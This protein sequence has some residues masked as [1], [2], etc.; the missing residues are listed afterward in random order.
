M[1][2]KR[3]RERRRLNLRSLGVLIVVLASASVGTYFVHG[4]QVKRNAGTLLARAR[5]LLAQG[6]GA[7]A[8][9]YYYRYLKF[10]PEDPEA[11]EEVATQMEKTAESERA[12]KTV[13]TIFEKVLSLPDGEGGR[14]PG[15][16]VLRRRQ[17]HRALAL[18]RYVD[19]E[20][21]ILILAGYPVDAV[22]ESEKGLLEHP[23]RDG[24]LLDL[25]GQSLEGQG[26]DKGRKAE[27]A[28]RHALKAGWKRPETYIRLAVLLRRQF[29]QEKVKDA[30]ATVSKMVEEARPKSFKVYLARAGYYAEYGA[31][32][33]A[34]AD[35]AEAYK[36]APKEAGVL[37]AVAQFHGKGGL[38]DDRRPSLEKGAKLYPYD[39]R[40]HLALARLAMGDDRTEARRR[41]LKGLDT[42]PEPP[43]DP[44][45]LTV[46]WSL[47][48]SLLDLGGKD[49][50]LDPAR[51]AIQRL[52]KRLGDAPRVAFLK[53]RVLLAKGAWGDAAKAF[54]ELLPQVAD[55]RGLAK[56]ARFYLGQCY[57]QLGDAE[58]ALAA[59]RQ[60]SDLDSTWPPARL[61]AASA[62]I[63]LGRI[64]DALREYN[65]LGPS[66]GQLARARLRVLQALGRPAG[67]RNWGPVKAAL[68]KAEPDRA[69]SLPVALL[70]AEVY[71]AEDSK[72]GPAK[73]E[74]WMASLRGRYK[75]KAEYWVARA[76]LAER[77]G[78]SETVLALLDEAERAAGPGVELRLARARYWARRPGP[79]ATAALKALE[80]GANKY[81]EGERARLWHGLAGAYYQTG[82]LKSAER[83]WGQVAALKSQDHDLAVRLLLFDLALRRGDEPK[84]RRRIAEIHDKEG[85]DGVLWRYAEAA[86][87]VWLAEGGEKAD[88]AVAARHLQ[89][90]SKRRPSWSRVVLLRAALLEQEGKTS[91][92]ISAYQD[93]VA[94]GERRPEVIRRLV[95]LLMERGRYAEAAAALARL[96]EETPP[97]GDL[98]QLAAEVSLSNHNAEQAARLADS[99]AALAG[100]DYRDHVALAQVFGVLAGGKDKEGQARAKLDEKAR[101]HF[102]LAIALGS[103]APQPWVAFVEYLVRTGRK[104]DAERVLDE[105]RTKLS[106]ADLP[107]ALAPGYELLGRADKAREQ[108]RAALRSYPSSGPVFRLVADYYLRN[109]QPQEAEPLLRRLRGGAVKVSAG[110]K[111]W[112]NRNLAL[113]L[114]MRGKLAE[115]LKLLDENR[116]PR[117]EAVEDLRTRAVVLS[118]HAYRWP[119]AIPVLEDLRRRGPLAPDQEFLLARLYELSGNWRKANGQFLTLL[120]AHQGNRQYLLHY[121]RSLLG[122]GLTR[123]AE[124]WLARLEKVEGTNPSPAAVDLKAMLLKKQGKVEE[125]VALAYKYKNTNPALAAS[126][127]GRLGSK[128]DDGK[129]EVAY[130]TLVAQAGVAANVFAYAGFL[131]RRHRLRE[132]LD[133]CEQGWAKAGPELAAGATV[134]VLRAAGPGAPGPQVRR[135][136][137]WLLAALKKTSAPG[138][139]LALADLRDYEGRYGE[140]EALYR[141]VLRQD[142]GNA[143]AL[144][145]LAWLLSLNDNNHDEA[146]RCV[147]RALERVGPAAGLL[148]TRGVILLRRGDAR[149]AVRDLE[150]VA[151]REPSASRYFHLAQAR[152]GKGSRVGTREAWRCAQGWGLER[153][154]LHPLEQSSYRDLERA[155]ARR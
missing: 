55:T 51:K 13:F 26:P 17:V 148:D 78:K 75:T 68:E 7:Q 37:L 120:A 94:R 91:R 62:A 101:K 116:R 129:A 22:E 16:T 109:G 8:Q 15:H 32:D 138:V 150:E 149:A 57:Q 27:E 135:V 143:H 112:A 28:Y 142:P 121:T 115:A 90:V 39:A 154:T 134:G 119:E 117:G 38:P 60:A 113:A 52:E 12:R 84:M 133:L 114:G 4:Y 126:I 152:Q 145:N 36:L 131:S 86:R 125:A 18:Q 123:E 63:S 44:A 153:G 76:G 139:R 30:D 124:F 50:E 77:M 24:E 42:V 35:V 20:A 97:T 89:E 59:Y 79:A 144:N 70:W 10:R 122:R 31:E 88:L 3:K 53:A 54:R 80:E 81:K 58:K 98:L 147:N 82:D 47:A 95:R 6:R 40:F 87:L 105:A 69:K 110:D 83:L 5:T 132:A 72:R 14:D 106:A 85:S 34:A 11:L 146:L 25:F 43:R 111:A 100:G 99:A 9:Q 130:K 29:F 46:L 23:P 66:V 21:H 155:V 64:D 48:D 102:R 33:K 140:A 1:E 128:A 2:A 118:V 93:A 92:A 136:E 71:A 65:A 73:A 41:L 107:F 104:K 45:H 103:K 151:A 56:R 67:R 108:Y 61:G 96:D 74:T 127:L 137:G 141:E 49:K 19:A